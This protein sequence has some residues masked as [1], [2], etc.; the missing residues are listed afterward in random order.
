MS[1]R[2][3][4][5]KELEHLIEKREDEGDRR[6]QDRR[7]KARSPAGAEEQRQTNDRRRKR[8]RKS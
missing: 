2:L 1:K 8:R 5:P 6:S 7:S 3:T 4:V